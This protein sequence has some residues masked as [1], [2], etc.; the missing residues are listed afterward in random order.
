MKFANEHLVVVLLFL[1]IGVGAQEHQVA[2]EGN[3]QVVNSEL[4]GIH[5]QNVSTQKA[6]I[7]D[8]YG[9]F[10][11][12]VSLKDTLLFSSVQLK[13]KELVITKEILESKKIIIPLEEAENKLEEVVVMPFH[14]TGDLSKD[15]G[16][17]KQAAVSST[18]LGLPN[19]HVVKMTYNERKLLEADR[20]T[21][22][23]VLPL[24]F[25]INTHKILNRISG[26]TKMLKERIVREEKNNS[27]EQLLAYYPEA[28]ITE[29]L[30]IPDLQLHEFIYFCEVDKNFNFLLKSENQLILWEFLERKSKVFLKQNKPD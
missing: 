5:V 22:L 24:G 4:A 1:A 12:V 18:S 14:L 9:F 17:L 16:N 27:V 29:N 6:T 25:A 28:I 20:G 19:T 13:K 21:M 30:K 8:G 26:R 3:V 11:I 10:S 23:R 2:L 7:T 15:A